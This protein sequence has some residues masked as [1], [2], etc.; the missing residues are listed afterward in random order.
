MAHS[1]ER[2]RER[3]V[4]AVWTPKLDST[5]LYTTEKRKSMNTMSLHQ[6]LF[7]ANMCILHVKY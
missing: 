7:T 3:G 5:A 2:E 4:G 6:N 1:L